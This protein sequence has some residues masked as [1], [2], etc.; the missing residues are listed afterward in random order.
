MRNPSEVFVVIVEHGG[1]FN[2]LRYPVDLGLG[3]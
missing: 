1:A 2:L 3:L